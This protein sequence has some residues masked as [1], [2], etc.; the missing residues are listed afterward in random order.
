L[1][2]Q[3]AN[4]QQDNSR[5]TLSSHLELLLALKQL[6]ELCMKLATIVEL[7]SES[8]SFQQKTDETIYSGVDNIKDGLMSNGRMLSGVM[9]LGLLYLK[10]MGELRFGDFQRKNMTLIVLFQ[11]LSMVV[12]E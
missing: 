12:V 4:N 9:N 8:H 2:S 10:V 7:L 11:Q 6:R 5:A 3:I 1:L